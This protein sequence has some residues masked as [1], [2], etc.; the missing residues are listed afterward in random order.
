MPLDQVLNDKP[1]IKYLE[2]YIKN[3]VEAVVIDKVRKGFNLRPDFSTCCICT[4]ALFLNLILTFLG[5][6][7]YVWLAM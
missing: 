2:E 5:T 1:R 6:A 7:H 3:A 4:V